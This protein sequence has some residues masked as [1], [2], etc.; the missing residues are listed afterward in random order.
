M[1]PPDGQSSDRHT[2][3]GF[4][5]DCLVQ[6]LPF[7]RCGIKRHAEALN[8]RHGVGVGASAVKG[9]LNLLTVNGKV[10]KGRRGES[11]DHWFG[12]RLN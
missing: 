2:L 3:Q 9:D 8:V 4:I 7:R 12:V 1:N 10:L 6:E 11:V 5:L